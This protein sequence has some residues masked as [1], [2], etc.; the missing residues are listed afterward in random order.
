[1]RLVPAIAGID[2]T[3]RAV[4]SLAAGPLWHAESLAR[5]GGAWACAGAGSA[6]AARMMKGAA[7]RT[8]VKQ[9]TRGGMLRARQV[10]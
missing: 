5:S 8:A 2:P 10:R 6:R 4:R 7:R 1:M 3:R 9:Q